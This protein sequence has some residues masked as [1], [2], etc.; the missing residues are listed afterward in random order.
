[1][2]GQRLVVKSPNL[3]LDPAS[4][5]AKLQNTMFRSVFLTHLAVRSG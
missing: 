1:M 5:D 3:I 2:S 4:L